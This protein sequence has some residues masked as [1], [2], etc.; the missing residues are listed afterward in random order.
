MPMLNIKELHRTIDIKRQNRM[1]CYEIILEKIH[2]KI[3]YTTKK[4]QSF[5]IYVIPEYIIGLP[6]I[7]NN[8]CTEYVIKKLNENGFFVK[9]TFP[10]LLYISWFRENES[11]SSKVNTNVNR[12]K[13]LTF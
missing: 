5:C 10:N 7:N 11:T 8:E 13:L 6:M 2:K 3:I 1:K 4:E 9:Y 12:Q